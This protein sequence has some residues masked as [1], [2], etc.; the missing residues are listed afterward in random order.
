M[1]QDAVAN[2][3]GSAICLKTPPYRAG[4]QISMC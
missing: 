3:C 1:V 2:K 4:F